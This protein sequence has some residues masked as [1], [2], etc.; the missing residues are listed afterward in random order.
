MDEGRILIAGCGYVGAEL[1]RR[2]VGD[3]VEVTGLGRRAEAPL[4][5]IDWIRGDLADRDS[6]T[7]LATRGFDA[8]VF[9]ASPSS[10]DETGYRRIFTEGL[11]NLIDAL[12]AASPAPKRLLFTASTAVYG[13]T[14]G[15]WV[16]EDSPTKP[17]RYNG[18]I[19]LQAERLLE[20]APFTTSSLRLGG[21]YGPGRTRLID[22]VRRGDAS[23]DPGPP[24]FTNRIHRDDAAGALRHL[25]GV[26]SPA[27]VYLGV[28]SDPA[29]RN[30][31]TRFLAERL[32]VPCPAVADAPAPRRAGSKRCRNTRLLR[33]GYHFAYP[34][35]REG[36]GEMIERL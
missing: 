9:A 34:S 2:L 25:L 16:D 3:G 13:Q 23:L 26:E 35:F 14:D 15:E 1:A 4:E 6:L 29:A 30:E 19:L 11:G 12:A 21:I 10:P 24:Q 31:V 20:A 5:A 32:G 18:R 22:Q 36:Y 27:S 7:E 17:P 8:A 33:S 28:D